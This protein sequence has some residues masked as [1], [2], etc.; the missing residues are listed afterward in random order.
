[1]PIEWAV[2]YFTSK[3]QYMGSFLTDRGKPMLDDDKHLQVG[4]CDKIE[5]AWLVEYLHGLQLVELLPYDAIVKVVN[6]IW[7]DKGEIDLEER[8]EDVTN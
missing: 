7:K 2:I 6:P 1:M 5:N 8:L 3:K 4:L